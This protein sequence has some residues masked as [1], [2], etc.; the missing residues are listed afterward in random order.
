MPKRKTTRKSAAQARSKK[1][2]KPKAKP[3]AKRAPVAVAVGDAVRLPPE[4]RNQVSRYD[5]RIARAARGADAVEGIICSIREIGTGKLVPKTSKSMEG[6]VL[7]VL[8]N[9]TF[10]VQFSSSRNTG[11]PKGP[12]RVSDNPSWK[13]LR[14][15]LREMASQQQLFSAGSAGLS[16][17]PLSSLLDGWR[18]IKVR[19]EQIELIE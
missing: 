7:E 2:A 13:R 19:A 4:T 10:T 17:E 6:Y 8:H 14:A 12:D 18:V 9:D 5:A 3:R 11:G 15:M 16:R 1:K